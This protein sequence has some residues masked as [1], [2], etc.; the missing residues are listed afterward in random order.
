MEYIEKKELNQYIWGCISGRC[1]VGNEF[2]IRK[3]IETYKQGFDNLFDYCWKQKISI[4]KDGKGA[5]SLNKIVYKQMPFSRKL[6]DSNI[7]L[8][9]CFALFLILVYLIDKWT[10]E[11]YSWKWVVEKIDTHPIVLTLSFLYL[12]II[13]SSVM[14]ADGDISIPSI[15]CLLFLCSALILIA[16]EPSWMISDNDRQALEWDV[17]NLA[18]LKIQLAKRDVYL[19]LLCL[20]LIPILHINNQRLNDLHTQKQQS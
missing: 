11:D 15:M 9:V 7:S 14:K 16:F 3:T 8:L 10:I 12:S 18:L 1:I 17:S 2:P 13:A 4:H 19:G 6:I 20:L 5:R